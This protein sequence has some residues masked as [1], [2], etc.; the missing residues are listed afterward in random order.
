MNIAASGEFWLPETP[1]V[2]VRGAFKADAGEQPEAVLAGALV[3]DPRVTRSETGG[4][5]YAMG[6]AG[7]VKASLAITM[8]GR[9]DSGDSV[10]LV[11]A[12][13]WGDPAG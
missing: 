6:P 2:T 7:A 4:L 10:T 13:N 5:T 11:T 1:G 12:Q 9:L 8:Q 3:E